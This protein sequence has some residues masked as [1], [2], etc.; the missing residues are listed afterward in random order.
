MGFFENYTQINYLD[1]SRID[2]DTIRSMYKNLTPFQQRSFDSFVLSLIEYSERTFYSEGYQK[3]K[4]ESTMRDHEEGYEEGY[5]DGF[6]A[7]QKSANPTD[8]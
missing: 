2:I 1:L 8:S 7:G 5:E 6:I 4:E 3:A